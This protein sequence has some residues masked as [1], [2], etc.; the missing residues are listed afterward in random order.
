M[1]FSLAYYYA[2]EYVWFSVSECRLLGDIDPANTSV[3]RENF[4]DPVNDAL[5]R[6]IFTVGDA[7]KLVM[8]KQI[9]F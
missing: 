7:P 1:S 8:S 3:F 2:L 6:Q 9:T 5:R 4:L